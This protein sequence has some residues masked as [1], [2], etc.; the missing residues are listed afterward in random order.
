MRLSFQGS[1]LERNAFAA[2]LHASTSLQPQEPYPEAWRLRLH[3]S[4][5]KKNAPLMG[6]YRV[7]N[8]QLEKQADK[9]RM[10]ISKM[11]TK[12]LNLR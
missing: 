9:Y 7:L 8:Y 1:A 3:K 6:R 12:S 5:H 10:G 2:L 4:A 11:P